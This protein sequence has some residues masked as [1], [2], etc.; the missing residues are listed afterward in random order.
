MTIAVYVAI[1]LGLL[2][3]IL[4]CVRR[5]MQYARAPVHLRW[6]LYPVPHEDPIRAAHGGSSFELSEPAKR[7]ADFHFGSELRAMVQEIAFLKGLWE[8]NRPLWYAS[9]LFHAGL[10]LTIA[11]V[12]LIAVM[13]SL[14]GSAHGTSIL[15]TRGACHAAAYAGF[16][17]TLAGAVALLYRRLTDPE[18]KNYTSPA[19]IFNLH[20]F[21]LTYAI[22]A[23]GYLVRGEHT[24]GAGAVLR[25]AATFD[26]SLVIS[27]GFGIGL[28]LASALIAYIPLTHMAHFIAK[29]FTYHAVRWDDRAN[30]RGGPIETTIAGYLAYKPTWAAP[31]IGADGH[32][33]WGEIAVSSPVQEIRK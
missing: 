11:A 9:F 21:I 6:E 30:R 7:P 25:G 16:G 19:D 29:Y 20:F 27:R 18:L 22:L 10:Y 14:G 15:S 23:A 5:V 3:F 8:F 1:Y 32:K 4:G 24:A 17:L 13:A 33:T 26:T 31:H 12:V 2:I 28:I